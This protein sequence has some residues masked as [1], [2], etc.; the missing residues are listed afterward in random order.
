M[1]ILYTFCI[2][3]RKLLSK[4]FQL[5]T[6]IFENIYNLEMPIKFSIK[7]QKLPIPFFIAIP[8]HIIIPNL[9]VIKVGGIRK[10]DIKREIDWWT[11]EGAISKFWEKAI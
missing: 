7:L 8:I 6:Y 11:P 2:G 10:V 1:L 9:R 5:S 3:Q 4:N